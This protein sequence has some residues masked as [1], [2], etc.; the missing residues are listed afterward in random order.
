MIDAREV[1][2]SKMK[3]WLWLS[4]VV[5]MVRW[6][7]AMLIMRHVYSALFLPLT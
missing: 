2:H 6:A 5:I 1:R 4:W 3:L 7:T